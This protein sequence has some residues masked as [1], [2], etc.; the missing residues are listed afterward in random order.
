MSSSCLPSY[1]ATWMA[2]KAVTA[3]ETRRI[4]A[5]WRV[6]AAIT[7]QQSALVV[8]GILNSN[9]NSHERPR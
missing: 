7:V 1:P 3:Q 8:S 6:T 9:G 2:N 4:I 5:A